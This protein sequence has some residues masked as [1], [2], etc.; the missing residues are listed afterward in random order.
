MKSV[1]AAEIAGLAAWRTLQSGDR[2]GGIVFSEAEQVVL[3]PQRSQHR[4][5]QLLHE[6]VRLNER[7]AKDP[8]TG[9]GHL[10]TALEAAL[11]MARH[12]FLVV[13]ISDLDGAD[14]RTRELATRIASHND[15]LVV[16]VYDPLG[17]QLSG[18]PGMRASDRGRHW[19]IPAGP[20]FEKAFRTAFERLLRHWR[21]IFQDLRIPLFPLS[22]ASPVI[23]QIH[24]LLGTRK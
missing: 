20:A 7:L 9:S 21:T 22:T 24:E 17:A 23:D 1:T 5:L 4:V 15:M 3:R 2:V 16:A 12:D 8:P 10:N 13:L 19:G 6:V 11:N 14:D 18:M